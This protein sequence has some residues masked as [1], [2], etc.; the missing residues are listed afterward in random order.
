[1]SISQ[2]NTNINIPNKQINFMNINKEQRK[3]SQITNK[4]KHKQ[5]KTSQN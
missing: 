1:M 3:Q 5:R 2:D 4:Y